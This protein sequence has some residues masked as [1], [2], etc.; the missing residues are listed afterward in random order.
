MDDV[1]NSVWMS[2]DSLC[3]E[4]SRDLLESGAEVRLTVEKVSGIFR[5]RQMV[6]PDED[7]DLNPCPHRHYAVK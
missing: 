1:I 3:I 5:I 6:L 4:I 2:D 7:A